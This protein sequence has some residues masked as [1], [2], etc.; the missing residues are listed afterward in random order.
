MGHKNV[1]EHCVEL[2]NQ[3]YNK[4]WG[5]NFYNCLEISEN[6]ENNKGQSEEQ[7][8][9]GDSKDQK[10][11]GEDERRETKVVWACKEKARKLL[12]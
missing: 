11:R 6:G 3:R 8:H 5:T 1:Y 7:V 10:N 4:C 2:R 12:R 9:L